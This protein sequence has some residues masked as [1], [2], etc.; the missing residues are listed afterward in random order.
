M[1]RNPPVRSDLSADPT[2]HRE[3]R[4]SLN[5]HS[6]K[7]VLTPLDAVQ[8][9]RS[10]IVEADNWLAALRLA[11]HQLGEEG[12]VPS[13][14][15]C[16]MSASGEVT[17][18]DAAQRR[19]Y[20]LSRC[21][22]E[23]QRASPPAA[24]ASERP[25]PAAASPAPAKRSV[26]V[27][28]SPTEAAEIRQK[29]LAAKPA[30]QPPAPAPNAVAQAPAVQASAPS[31]ADAPRPKRSVTVSYSAEEAAELRKKLQ[32]ARPVA[33]AP[34]EP[35]SPAPN[36]PSAPGAA[37]AAA[38]V[39]VQ[40]ATPGA[41]QAE[42]PRRA[43]VAYIESPLAS[44]QLIPLSSREQEPDARS[45]LTY[46]ERCYFTP[47]TLD[48]AE[49][50]A[51]LMAEL[52]A[53]QQS[54]SGAP[55]GQYVNLAVFDHVFQGKPQSPPLA[56]LQWKDWRGAPVFALGTGQRL[57]SWNPPAGVVHPSF[58]PPP[59]SVPPAAFA[60]PLPAPSAPASVAPPASVPQAAFGAPLPA[61]SAPASAP[62]AAFAAPLPAVATSSPGSVPPPAAVPLPAQA[63]PLPAAAAPGADAPALPPA[64]VAPSSYPPIQGPAP[65]PVSSEPHAQAAPSAALDPF[66]P[67]APAP[68]AAAPFAPAPAAASPV[69]GPPTQVAAPAQ[70]EA[71]A[72]AQT[73]APAAESTERREPT[74][75][76][77]R[78]L[79]TAFEAVQDLYFLNTP[80]EAL[81]FAIKLLGDL[82]PCEAASGC[83]YDINTDEFRFVA[84][85]GPGATE[86]RAE[87]VPSRAGLLGLAAYSQR[88]HLVIEGAEQ[89]ERYDPAVDGRI[90]LEAHTLAYFP[91][92]KNDQLLGMLQLI[93]R[94]KRAFT[95]SDCAV[96]T[97]VATQVS[98]F[99]LS[100][101]GAV[102]R[103]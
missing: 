35:A 32:A 56:T 2:P 81:E 7:L 52:R 10:V 6:W 51:A 57:P 82:I 15:S 61:A 53:I 22:S 93:N 18:L 44:A 5:A 92:Q 98:E 45:P 71:P 73:P 79:A 8:D 30:S 43:T 88:D 25:A 91:L 37:S 9:A 70:F 59:A 58:A 31:A 48:A 55:R 64:F 16:V 77:D 97:Y 60:A 86:R 101:R 54:L 27:A 87:A 46:R 85:S 4:G 89:D 14:A 96:G 66:A 21:A 12:G 13:G 34:S 99:L 63:A 76:Q 84:L 3:Q 67:V 68:A 95:E 1:T 80:V 90:G 24:S 23:P 78:R 50:E 11:R 17:I 19:K 94:R 40:G 38:W 28:Y 72:P 42:P 74:G 33:G 47:R 26:T 36:A 39:P 29:L 83:I 20:V 100:R 102:R 103:R 62:P 65:T 49:L 75:E 69:G 41:A